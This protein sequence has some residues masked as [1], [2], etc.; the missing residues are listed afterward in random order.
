MGISGL[1]GAVKEAQESVHISRFKG[2]TLGIDGYVWLH[3]GAF[4]CSEDIVLE[5]PT[6]KYVLYFIKK[7]RLLQ[8]FGVEPYVV[9]DGGPL[10]SKKKTELEREMNRKNNTDRGID[11]LKQG[12]RKE[13]MSYFQKGVNITPLL[14]KAVIEEL[15]KEKINYIVAPYEADAQLAFLEK[16][17]IID[18]IITEDSDLV[19]FGCK[20]V[21][22]K[23]NDGGFGVLFDRDNLRLVKDIPLKGWDDNMFRK[24]CILSGCDYLDSVHGVALKRSCKYLQRSSDIQKIVQIMK[25]EGLK[26]PNTYVQDF[27][28]AEKTFM[29]QKVFDPIVKK[30]RSLEEIRP[31]HIDPDM[32]YI[33]ENIDDTLAYLISIG[34]VDPI[35][36]QPFGSYEHTNGK[37]HEKIKVHSKSEPEN[38]LLMRWLKPTDSKDINESKMENLLDMEIET[39]SECK[40]LDSSRR[41]ST[42]CKICNGGDVYKQNIISKRSESEIIGSTNRNN[43]T[44]TTS[45]Y[46]GSQAKKLSIG[47]EIKAKPSQGSSNSGITVNGRETSQTKLSFQ[48]I[49]VGNN[50]STLGSSFQQQTRFQTLS[51]PNSVIEAVETPK[52][53]LSFS[54]SFT[55]KKKP[56]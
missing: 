54:P 40:H 56:F 49:S 31:E 35:S 38:R 33:G 45:K 34:E 50:S 14:A 1:I 15:K 8:H 42:G 37:I 44:I 19:V 18:G 51:I 39:K 41:L 30:L 52:R 24:M 28:R 23:L 12:K 48:T 25:G 7:I 29:Y 9:F 32:D 26:V 13:A 47:F 10:I 2:K 16:N 5:K 36:K 11:L 6:N 22:F 46:F 20:K 21:I 27:Q 4:G 3:K 53:K 17:G 55:I 43:P